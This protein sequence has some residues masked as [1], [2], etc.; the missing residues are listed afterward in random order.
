MSPLRS[1]MIFF[2]AVTFD[3]STAPLRDPSNVKDVSV[4]GRSDAPGDDGAVDDSIAFAV[5]P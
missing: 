3:F 4:V 1:A 2:G 5:V